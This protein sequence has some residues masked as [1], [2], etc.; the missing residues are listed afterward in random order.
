MVDL[1][2]KGIILGK[3]FWGTHKTAMDLQTI[4]AQTRLPV[5]TIRY[6]LDHRLLPGQRR[7]TGQPDLVGRARVLTDLEGF[8]VA[9]AATL[10]ESGVRR[11][12]V[13]D[14]MSALTGYS[15][16]KNA[17]KTRPMGAIQWAFEATTPAKAMLGDGVN[18]RFELDREDTGWIQPGTFARLADDYQPRAIVTIDLAQL[19]QAFLDSKR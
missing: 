1:P 8:S 10:L 12:A 9:C 3:Q 14:F 5:R 11:E 7:V 2:T 6:V 18:L 17:R 4:A 13:V 16:G 15:V 19:R